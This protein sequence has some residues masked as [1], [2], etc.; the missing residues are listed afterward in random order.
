[1]VPLGI[2]DANTG[3]SHNDVVDVGLRP[4]DAAIVEHDRAV[5]CQ[6][7]ESRANALL[8]HGSLRPR[9]RR[10][11]FVRE[12]ENDATEAWMTRTSLLFSP[13]LLTLILGSG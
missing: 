11:R 4:R 10:L 7:S 2:D 6:L 5:R 3:R 12:R 13:L 8:T 1:V 9:F